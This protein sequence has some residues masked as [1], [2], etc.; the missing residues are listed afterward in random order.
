MRAALYFKIII[1]LTLLSHSAYSRTCFDGKSD[2]ETKARLSYLKTAFI[3]SNAGSYQDCENLLTKNEESMGRILS[4]ALF[5]TL[6]LPESRDDSAQLYNLIDE[7]SEKVS[8]QLRGLQNE[9]YKRDFFGS[10]YLDSERKLILERPDE[11]KQTLRQ[12]LVSAFNNYDNEIEGINRTVNTKA[13][14]GGFDESDMALIRAAHRKYERIIDPIK[15]EIEKTEGREGLKKAVVYSEYRGRAAPYKLMFKRLETLKR[16]LKEK[17]NDRAMMITVLN[18]LPYGDLDV[19]DHQFKFRLK[20]F[21][22]DKNLKSEMGAFSSQQFNNFLKTRGLSLLV[23]NET[24]KYVDPKLEGDCREGLSPYMSVDSECR[25]AILDMENPLESFILRKTD[26]EQRKELSDSR[27]FMCDY[28]NAV[29]EKQFNWKVT[30]SNNSLTARRS[31]VK[32]SPELEEASPRDLELIW[33]KS[34]ILKSIFVNG[35]EKRVASD[36]YRLE[37]NGGEPVSLRIIDKPNLQ[38]FRRAHS[39][40][41]FKL[42]DEYLSFFEEIRLSKPPTEVVTTIMKDYRSLRLVL[43]EMKGCCQ[44][45][46]QL[47][48]RCEK[49]GIKQ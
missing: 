22:V 4:A 5:T 36:M 31:L 43:A 48:R 1:T 33:D 40:I 45:A 23:T 14:P 26:E 2:S 15:R 3:C 41:Q 21:I 10:E 27:S 38:N 37:L 13:K 39:K 25:T 8:G 35:V 7:V 18:H 6:S 20:R 30:C 16:H 32:Y 44:D 34:G 9:S 17:P 42:N 28:V 11:V 46:S 19:Y 47:G 24:T 29:Y 12:K 49:Y